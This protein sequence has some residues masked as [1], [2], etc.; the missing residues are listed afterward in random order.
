M[1]T[2]KMQSEKDW[3]KCSNMVENVGMK[4]SV[5]TYSLSIFFA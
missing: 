2:C 3:A 4:K 1:Y 5:I